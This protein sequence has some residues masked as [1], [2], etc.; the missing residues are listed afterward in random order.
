MERGKLLN[1]E[2]LYKMDGERVLI[3]DDYFS[4]H[5]IIHT[6][7]LHHKDTGMGE[8]VA[9]LV[10]DGSDQYYGI[11]EGT[12]LDNEKVYE[13]F[14]E[15]SIK[16]GFK[17]ISE[18]QFKEDFKDTY[19][20]YKDLKLPKR[21]TKK[22][23][24]YD[25][26]APFTFTLEPGEDIK[27]PTGISAYMLEDEVLKAFPRS[28]YGFKFYIRLANTVAIIDADYSE[29]DNEG[30]IWI[31]LR[32]EGSKQFVG[33]EGQGICQVMFQKYLLADGDNF[34]DGEQRNGG[35]GSTTK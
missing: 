10:E 3:H 8:T 23:A 21:G 33:R 4:E 29:S 14:K 9:A 34:E 12:F 19:V 28:G 24:G 7:R 6:V 35:F 27:I 26:F 16:R 2:D 18:K 31:K 5:D 17:F 25:I 20:E 22:S 11:D 1:R 15:P 30:H 32:N 13:I